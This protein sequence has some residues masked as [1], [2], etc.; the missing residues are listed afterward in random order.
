LTI[1]TLSVFYLTSSSGAYPSG[2]G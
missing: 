1:S 2:V